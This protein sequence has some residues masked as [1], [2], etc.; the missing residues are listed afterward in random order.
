MGIQINHKFNVIK[1][2]SRA[3]VDGCKVNHLRETYKEQLF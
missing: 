1:G 2:A 3:I